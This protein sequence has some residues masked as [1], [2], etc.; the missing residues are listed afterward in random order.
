MSLKW[1]LLMISFAASVSVSCADSLLAEF[2]YLTLTGRVFIGASETV[3][4]LAAATGSYSPPLKITPNSFFFAHPEYGDWL[5]VVDA[6]DPGELHQLLGKLY[7]RGARRF[8]LL[9]EVRG[10]PKKGDYHLP[11]LTESGAPFLAVNHAESFTWK[12]AKLSLVRDLVANNQVSVFKSFAETH[13]LLESSA[14]VATDLRT[15]AEELVRVALAG[16]SLKDPA[17]FTPSYEFCTH[18]GACIGDE[19]FALSGK[20]V[21]KGKVALVGFR[22]AQ[23][24][25]DIY[26]GVAIQERKTGEL[27]WHLPG[28]VAES[29]PGLCR[30]MLS[31]YCVNTE[32]VLAHGPG[33]PARIVGVFPASDRIIIERSEGYELVERSSLKPLAPLPVPQEGM[34]SYFKTILPR[35]DLKLSELLV[36]WNPREVKRKGELINPWATCSEPR[37][38]DHPQPISADGTPV[39]ACVADT[40]Y[41]WGDPA[42]VDSLR[43]PSKHKNWRQMIYG[44]SGI[45]LVTSPAST[46]GY[47]SVDGS[48][49]LAIRFKLRPGVKYKLTHFDPSV[50]EPVPYRARTVDEVEI[51][52]LMRPGCSQFPAKEVHDTVY[53]RYW[54]YR[55]PPRKEH[56]QGVHDA[57]LEYVI[58][59]LNVIESWS[60]GT[61]DFYDE[62]VRDIRRFVEGWDPPGA[63]SYIRRRGPDGMTRPMFLGLLTDHRPFTQGHL[64]RTLKLQLEVAADDRGEI[65]LNPHAGKRNDLRRRHFETTTPSWFNPR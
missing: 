57:G 28:D 56:P 47:G 12:G 42:Y 51:R 3:K 45:Y 65:F 4:R 44:D 5:L 46:F 63:P 30:P 1:F 48:G 49:G 14:I 36:E 58:C 41:Y 16:A 21:I 61:R 33:Q 7:Q 27:R 19:V 29:T 15:S 24:E 34:S 62:F 54:S 8:V 18:D 31:P 22:G 39:K 64:I 25:E 59:S 40:L 32:V 53:I 6:Q 37:L 26:L 9:T 20:R 43:G 11:A 52:Q 23:K 2:P 35:N 10:R 55:E 17:L 13:A 38:Q 50:L 60:Y